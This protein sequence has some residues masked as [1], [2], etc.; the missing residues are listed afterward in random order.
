[1][2]DSSPDAAIAPRAAV[3]AAIFRDGRVLLVKRSR[4][5]SAGVWSLPGGH[6]E[7]GETA[8]D[9]VHRELREET[10]ITAR[11]AEIA[12][13]KDV[14]HRTDRGELLFHRVVIVFCGEWL[15]GE[16]EAGDDAAAAGW[17]DPDALPELDTTEGLAAIVRSARVKLA[18]GSCP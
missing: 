4:P 5:P 10:A 9:A 18:G 11:I 16:H 15:S 14:I 17:Y 8:L 13:V 7:P 6:I 3:S 12:G 2:I 1:M